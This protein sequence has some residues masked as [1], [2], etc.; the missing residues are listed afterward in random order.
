MIYRFVDKNLKILGMQRR[1]G[2][3]L[4]FHATE[5]RAAMLNRDFPIPNIPSQQ[6]KSW[7]GHVTSAGATQGRNVKP[8]WK[9]LSSRTMRYIQNHSTV[10]YTWIKIND[11]SDTACGHEIW[12][13]SIGT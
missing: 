5:L 7:Q 10:A 2:S 12:I 6:G 8:A 13:H 1:S 3:A 11:K 4:D 9:I